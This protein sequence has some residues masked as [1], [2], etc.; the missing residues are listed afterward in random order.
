MKPK[1]FLRELQVLQEECCWTL[2]QLQPWAIFY[3]KTVQILHNWH[4]T[5]SI[6]KFLGRQS[7]QYSHC[8]AFRDDG[9][10]MR[11]WEINNIIFIPPTAF[12]QWISGM[13]FRL[14]AQKWDWSILLKNTSPSNGVIHV[15]WVH[16][17]HHMLL[18]M[19][20]VNSD[21]KEDSHILAAGCRLREATQ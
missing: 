10:V 15:L 16:S 20:P 6:G 11:L 5:G 7:P 17:V 14:I 19:L 13:D 2:G 9:K 8:K 18:S 21:S 4:W 12:S 3:L 1:V